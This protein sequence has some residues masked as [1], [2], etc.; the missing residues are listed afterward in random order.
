MLSELVA[1]DC[2]SI[3]H[4]CPEDCLAVSKRAG[5][6]LEDVETERVACLVKLDAILLPS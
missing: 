5:G 4:R 2:P 6:R 1:S 3:C